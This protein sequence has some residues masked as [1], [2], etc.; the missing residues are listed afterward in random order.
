MGSQSVTCHPAAVTLPPFAAAGHRLWNSLPVQ[1]RNPDITYRLF[2]RQLKRHFFG[3]HGHGALWL[4]ISSDLK[5]HLLTYLHYHGQRW[6]LIYRPWR[7]A[8]LSWPRVTWHRTHHSART[9][10]FTENEISYSGQNYAANSG[11][12]AE[13]TLLSTL[14]AHYTK[15]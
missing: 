11:S 13:M 9:K 4:L 7:D 5:K 15:L 8:R 6:Y 12:N 10:L 3:N 1:L 14:R 2:R